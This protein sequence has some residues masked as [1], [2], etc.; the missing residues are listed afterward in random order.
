MSKSNGNINGNGNGNNRALWAKVLDT[1]REIPTLRKDAVD[2]YRKKRYT[3]TEEILG[4]VKAACD[5]T[6]LIVFPN[7]G[8]VEQE[9]VGSSGRD[10][11]ATVKAELAWVILDPETGERESFPWFAFAT[12]SVE[13]ALGKAL[14]Y[15]TR[16]F[17]LKFFLI[18]YS[19]EDP[20]PAN[21]QQYNQQPRP[22]PRR[23]KAEVL[24]ELRADLRWMN[25]KFPYSYP[26]YL[27]N[28]KID[29]K[30]TADLSWSEIAGLAGIEYSI[31]TDAGNI[32]N[33]RYCLHR[34][35]GSIEKA[36]T[37]TPRDV[38]KAMAAICIEIHKAQTK[39]AESAAE[40]ETAKKQEPVTA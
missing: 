18:D 22:E 37:L 23:P 40:K 28:N 33:A 6:G 20:S 2:E 36:E 10:A 30:T 15:A 1:R 29:G 13:R 11:T 7:L 24:E 38:G 12:E 19:E 21:P 34:M 9:T 3:S 35:A 4:A 39:A 5:K 27:D 17:M 8:N 31:R 16:S 25:E 14:S 32:A 26:V